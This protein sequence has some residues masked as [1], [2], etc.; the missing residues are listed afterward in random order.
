MNMLASCEAKVEC[1][2]QVYEYRRI[3]NVRQQID[4]S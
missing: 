3:G 1:G 4:R 2:H